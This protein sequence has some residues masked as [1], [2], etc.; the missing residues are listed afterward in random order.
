M[1]I[2]KHVEICS[3]HLCIFAL[4]ETLCF[5]RAYQFGP[6]DIA[7][8]LVLFQSFERLPFEETV[9]ILLSMKIKRIAA[10]LVV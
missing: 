3:S 7:Y 8:I 10:D 4:K 9:V 5:F 1:L 2:K 6:A